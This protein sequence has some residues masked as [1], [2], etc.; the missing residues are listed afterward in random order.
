MAP[1]EKKYSFISVDTGTA[2]EESGVRTRRE[3]IDGEETIIVSSSAT[4]SET[5]NEAQ[6]E[7]L[8]VCPQTDHMHSDS[9]PARQS[10][11]DRSLQDNDINNDE[12][13]PFRRMQGA[14]IVCL[15]VL[16]V[17]FLVYFNFVR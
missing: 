11:A 3:I 16:I 2:E 8:R 15:I 7:G 14:I 6:E 5:A 17:A 10:E 1:E 12:Q 4:A 9:S 13:I